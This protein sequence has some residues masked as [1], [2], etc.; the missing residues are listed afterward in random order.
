MKLTFNPLDILL[1]TQLESVDLT[2]NQPITNKTMTYIQ[3]KDEHQLKTV[4]EY[5]SYKEAVKALKEYR[6]SDPHA[7]Y[8]LSQ[9]AC[10][11]WRWFY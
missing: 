5:T 11:A 4:A 3:R 7:V 10:K 8:Y 6:Y 1:L 9:R 2:D